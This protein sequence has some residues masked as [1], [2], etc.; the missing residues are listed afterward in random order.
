[1]AKMRKR[2]AD[3]SAPHDNGVWWLNLPAYYLPDL[4]EMA[5]K[6]G[7]FDCYSV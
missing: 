1:M 7:A 4:R 2:Q 3:C 5:R 6:V